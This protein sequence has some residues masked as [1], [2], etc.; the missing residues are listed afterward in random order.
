MRLLLILALIVIFVPRDGIDRERLL[1]RVGEAYD[2]T[3][4]TCV[5]DPHLCDQAMST[6]DNVYVKGGQA[7]AMMEGA[8]RRNLAASNLGRM[9]E[10]G[11]LDHYAISSLERGT[12]TPSDR[13]PAWRGHELTN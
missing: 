6:W 13:L 9:P 1:E 12:L 4:Q 5:R 3:S 10:D 8:V 7:L 11:Q 2:W